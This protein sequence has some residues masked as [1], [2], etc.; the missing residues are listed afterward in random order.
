[1]GAQ[2]EYPLSRRLPDEVAL[3]G[4]AVWSRYRRYPV[5]SWPWLRGRTLLFCVWVALWSLMMGGSVAVLATPAAG[6]EL[7]LHYFWTHMLVVSAGPALATVVRHRRLRPSL[8]R[9]GVV[10][11]IVAGIVLAFVFEGW[12]ELKAHQAVTTM[13]GGLDPGAL[14]IAEPSRWQQ[15]VAT[16]VNVGFRL[17]AFGLVGGGL[18][19][20]AYFGERRRWDD[21]RRRR[22]LER[23]EAEKKDSDLRLGMLQAQVE[24]HFLFNTLAS[25]RALVRKDPDRAEATLDALATHLR[26][27][28]PKLREGQASLDSTLGQQLDICDSYLALM[29]LRSGERLDYLIEAGP[30]LRSLPYPPML[31]LTLVENAVKHGIEPRS[32]PGRID[33]RART[34]GETLLVEVVDDGVGLQPGSGSGVGL[35]NVRGQLAA[36]YGDRASFQIVGRSG[37]GTRAVI[38]IP[39]EEGGPWAR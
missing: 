2:T 24:P 22:E 3:G 25:V 11:A 6:A 8:E 19:L 13:A 20:R 12:A 30:E 10:A 17:L 1:M 31:L 37:E 27:T 5:F 15:H 26:A 35:A 16:A 29:R 28:I 33:L 21:S 14:A 23:L 36:R 34:E 38:R 4:N 32:G 18:A 39:M 9:W 7:F